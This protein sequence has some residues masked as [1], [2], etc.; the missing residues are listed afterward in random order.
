[1]TASQG[2][3]LAIAG[4][5]VLLP[6]TVKAGWLTRGG[7]GA[8]ALVGGALAL[9]EG[10][11][12]VLLLIAFFTSASILTKTARAREV[13]VGA[14]CDQDA[15]GRRAGQVFANGGIAALCALLGVAGL[16]T[17][18][19]YAAAA[20]LAAATADTWAS[21]IGVWVGGGTRLLTNGRRVEPGCSGGVSWAGSASGAVGALSIAALASVGYGEPGMLAA[22]GLGG[23]GGMLVDSWVGGAWEE[24]VSWLGND[25]VNWIGTASGGAFGAAIGSIA[26]A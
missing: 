14:S 24:R 11:V 1:M 7:A 3:I 17:S 5:I 16:G 25:L 20:A 8:A 26:G 19:H 12:G 21:E 2:V 22:A 15:E 10:W 13:S 23:V 18:T 4:S 6:V 9:G